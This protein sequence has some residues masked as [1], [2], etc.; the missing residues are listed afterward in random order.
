MTLNAIYMETGAKSPPLPFAVPSIEALLG[1]MEDKWSFD[2]SYG[3]KSIANIEG[4]MAPGPATNSGTASRESLLTMGAIEK[5]EV[6]RWSVSPQ[7]GTRPGCGSE[8]FLTI[9]ASGRVLSFIAVCGHSSQSA[10]AY[11]ANAKPAS[12]GSRSIRWLWVGS[13]HRP[14]HY[15]VAPNRLSYMPNAKSPRSARGE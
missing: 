6:G 2:V 13:N 1:G 12:A 11:D 4:T 9:S 8:N 3:G 14:Q 10:I 5:T 7:L 15:A